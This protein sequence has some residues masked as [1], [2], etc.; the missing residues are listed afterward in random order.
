M[1][2]SY[3]KL[4]RS[5]ERSMNEIMKDLQPGSYL[6]G[7]NSDNLQP[8]ER[9]SF[10]LPQVLRPNL[11]ADPDLVLDTQARRDKTGSFMDK[12]G[13]YN[14]NNNSL[15]DERSY[16]RQSSQHSYINENGEKFSYTNHIVDTSQK[17][18]RTTLGLLGHQI[19]QVNYLAG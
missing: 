19:I 3:D 17:K 10:N 1:M 14:S 13:N 4:K 2:P 16:I 9:S 12:S 6:A 5:A 11:D 18:L 7:D 15:G 8:S